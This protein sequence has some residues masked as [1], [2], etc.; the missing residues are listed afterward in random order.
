MLTPLSAFPQLYLGSLLSGAFSGFIAAGVEANLHMALGYESWR[1]VFIIE[2]AVTGAF[3]I[4][5]LFVLP[6]YPATTKRLSVRERAL[7][8]YRLEADTGVKDE[9]D[10][11]SMVHNLKLALCDWK[12]WALAVITAC[13]TTASAF[14][15]VCNDR[16]ARHSTCKTDRALPS[17]LPRSSCPR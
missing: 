13:K 6:D 8:V 16:P 7:A 5:A 12:L 1:W 10:G 11:T 14:T 4:I 2:G 17:F 15:Q 3:A 9:G